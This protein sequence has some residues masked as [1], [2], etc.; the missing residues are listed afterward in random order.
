MP[1]TRTSGQGRPKGA[2]NKH[3]AS[4]KEMVL[5]ALQDAGGRE[6]LLRQANANPVA[7]M[8][9]VGR[10]LPLQVTGDPNGAPIMI[11]TGVIR[12]GD[13]I[14]D[15]SETLQIGVYTQTAGSAD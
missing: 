6:Y 10:V 12:E 9:L 4:I 1:V 15:S 5:G 7:F 3:T 2:M 8:G 13:I 14:E 11:V